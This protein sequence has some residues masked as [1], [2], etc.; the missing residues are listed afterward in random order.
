[1]DDYSDFY[2][3]A[4][5]LPQLMPVSGMMGLV[6]IWKA[7]AQPA[8]SCVSKRTLETTSKQC[9]P[10]QLERGDNEKKNKTGL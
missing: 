4:S 9:G 1:M 5:V 7:I 3:E 2:G 6:Y 10:R 8:D